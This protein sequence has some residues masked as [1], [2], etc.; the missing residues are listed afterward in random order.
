MICMIQQINGNIVLVTSGMI[1]ESSEVLCL[2]Y[3]PSSTDF[4]DTGQKQKANYI[5]Y[6]QIWMD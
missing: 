2:H 4:A 1:Q 6:L 5:N 3:Q